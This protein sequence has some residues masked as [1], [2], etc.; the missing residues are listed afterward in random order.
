[1]CSYLNIRMYADFNLHTEETLSGGEEDGGGDEET[2]GIKSWN[3]PKLHLCQHL[4]DNIEDKGASR[5][6]STKINEKIHGPLKT[7][8]HDCSN[9][10]NFEEQVC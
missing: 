1:L 3:F 4:F 5:N 7:S 8:Y 10:K 6:S 9:L 2:L